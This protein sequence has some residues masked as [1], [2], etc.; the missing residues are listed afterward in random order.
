[1]VEECSHQIE[2]IVRVRMGG[3]DRLRVPMGNVRLF[4]H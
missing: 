1:M 4:V 3:G 2:Q